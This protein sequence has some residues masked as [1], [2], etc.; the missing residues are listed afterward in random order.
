M[1]FC[2]Q[3]KTTENKHLLKESNKCLQNTEIIKLIDL[4]YPLNNKNE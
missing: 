4:R 2:R 3:P 1:E